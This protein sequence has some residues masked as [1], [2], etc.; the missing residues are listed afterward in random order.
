[1][2]YKLLSSLYYT[3]KKTY[4]TEY[5]NRLNSA[6]TVKLDIDI[7]GSP[8]FILIT[9]EISHMISSI[10]SS[11]RTLGSLSKK[12]DTDS[13]QIYRSSQLS[14]EAVM[15]NDLEG[16]ASTRKD[17][18]SILEKIRKNKNFRGAAKKFHGMVKSYD[19]LV[20]NTS[21]SIK[22]CKDIRSIYDKIALPE[23]ISN[24]KRNKPDGQYFRKDT[25]DVLNV[26][27]GK[28]IHSGVY[29]E[30]KL[31]EA[32]TAALE[33]LN[34]DSIDVL[35]RISAFHYLFGY[36]HP[37]Y[38][39]NGRTSRFIS[40]C[41]LSANFNILSGYWLANIIGENANSYYKMFNTVNDEKNKGDITP[42]VIYF[43][44]VLQKL[45]D[46]LC[47]DISQ[48]SEQYAYYENKINTKFTNT[49]ERSVMFAIL[50]ATV[51]DP[52]TVLES[53]LTR[54][55][56]STMC[57]LSKDKVKNITTKFANLFDFERDGSCNRYKLLLDKLDTCE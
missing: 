14:Y 35:I 8:A 17:I 3:D 4:E 53:G 55:N 56:I 2:E 45:F 48:K 28:V 46:Y 16:V 9:D 5:S 19:E 6:N 29:P 20:Q 39:G 27:S 23:V 42:F 1:M 57:S 15:T 18:L 26:K 43:L 25:V 41:L 40:S 12:M 44:G 37:F 32:M 10:Q 24:D 31:N 7:G 52:G 21:V 33:F 22:T 11:N 49:E 50:K 34:D 36:I 30:K 13:L 54:E 38:D 47:E 51:F